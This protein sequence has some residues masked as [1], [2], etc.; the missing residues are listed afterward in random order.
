MSENEKQIIRK[1]AEMSEQ[2]KQKV[3]EYIVNNM[4]K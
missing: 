1:V 3:L 4:K 2:D